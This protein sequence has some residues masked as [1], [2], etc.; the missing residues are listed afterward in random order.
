MK[1]MEIKTNVDITNPTHVKALNTFIEVI[2]S[3][4]TTTKVVE[5]KKEVKKKEV[6]K[7][8]DS[9]V[10]LISLRKLVSEKATDH[11]NEIKEKLTELGFK[12]VSSM[13]EEHFESFNEFLNNL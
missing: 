6:K 5:K 7:K 2:N 1:L 12:N 13:D 9:G 8:T 4:E 11:R 3:G 10:D